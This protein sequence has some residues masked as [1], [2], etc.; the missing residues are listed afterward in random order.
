MK[1]I[2]TLMLGMWTAAVATAQFPAAG[3]AGRGQGVPN[4]GHIYGKVV[5]S[6]GKPISDASVILLQS[7]YDSVS[8]KRKDVLLKGQSTKAGGEF[9]MEDLPMFGQLKLKISAT[10]YKPFEQ[11]VSFQM[12][13]PAGG[14]AARP[15]A[16]PSQAMA[17]MSNMVNGFDKDLGNIRLQLDMKQLNVVT[18]T[19][20]KPLVKMDI[21]KKV[22][23]VEKDMVNA[24][25]TALDLMKNVPSVNVDI[26]G[27]VTLRNAA[28]Q[29]YIDGRP[30]TLTLDQI[31]ADAI[32]SIEV[33]TNPSAKYDASGGGAGI[34]NIVLKKNRK[35]GYN[36][37]VRAG[38]DGHGAMNAGLNFNLRQNKFNFTAA[39]F[40]NQNRSV[41][42]GTTDRYDIADTPTSI[43]Q[44]NHDKNHG[45]F[46]FGSLGLD[47]F[48]TNRTT[49][50]LT[51]IKVHGSF[52][53]T[54]ILNIYSDSLYP[55]GTKSLYSQ[56]NSNTDRE[57]N[58]TGFT[59]GVKHLFPKEGETLTADMNFFQ[60]HNNSNAHYVTDYYDNGPGSN[61]GGTSQ[62]KVQGDGH[63]QF[64]TIQS[65]YV[66]P[67]SGKTKLEAGV[68][69]Q[70]QKLENNSYNYMDTLGTGDYYLVPS[71]STNYTNTNLVYAGY[72]SFTSNIKNF[73]YQVGLRGESSN[74]TGE[75]TNVKQSFGNSY[76]IS[77]F[78][79]LFLSQKFGNGNE[80]QMSYTRRINRPNFFQLIPYTDYTD[81][82]N[83]TRGN[84]NL[85][86]EFTNSMEMS[87][88]KNLPHNNTL[89]ASIYYKY[90][91][92][93]ITRYLDT[94]TNQ[95]TG[96]PGYVNT[97]VNAN[98]SQTMG[99]ELTTVMNVTKWF[100]FTANLNL[101]NSYIN[102]DNVYGSSQPN[103]W[104][105]FGKLTTNYKL[106]W[107][108]KLQVTGFYQSKTNMPV[109]QGGG[110]FGPPGGGAAQS[111]S[112]GYI[113]EFW[114]VDAALSRS[115]LKQ[116]AA[117]LSV[118]MGDIF[119]S[120]WNKQHSESQFFIQD[121]DRLRDPQLVRVNFTFRFGKMDVS[122]FKRKDMNSGGGD[123]ATQGMQQ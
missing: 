62:Q 95:L 120:R 37:S 44:E 28:P 117:T 118:S 53:P 100:D 22:Y 46:L 10:G 55:S 113:G 99:A 47:Y 14:N 60:G 110:G 36:G 54:Q 50:S 86:P 78:P 12:K 16:D 42:N 9:S 109:N 71:A 75:L 96:K 106:P 98:S 114:G 89:M 66:K 57:F 80:L 61:V 115:F 48:I 73:G 19:A 34:L 88:S 63:N 101:Y 69:F 91:T 112:Q 27:N 90:T 23:N 30:T 84:P 121:Y 33:I 68:R 93:L 103:L 76:P 77:L 26:D 43:H 79:S 64:M 39:G 123:G 104:S 38:V 15:N 65:D 3:G 87:Y 56:K 11:N 116:D 111:A 67:F 29:I 7:K 6:L 25:G 122:L 4:M 45:G 83:I 13:M 92:D 72:V 49:I 18:V 31:P 35:T 97:W 82:L 105:W 70:S 74:Y 40:F 52:T 81:S 119:R 21:D 59:F 85:V 1:K 20:S 94:F 41:T 2:F 32:E 17:N 107:K 58:A 8:K 24:G 102:T 5:D 51:G 108:V